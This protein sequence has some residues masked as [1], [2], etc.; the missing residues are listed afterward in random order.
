M[1]PQLP[2]I[3]ICSSLSQK[4]QIR[5]KQEY[6]GYLLIVKSNNTVRHD[7]FLRLRQTGDVGFDLLNRTPAVSILFARLESE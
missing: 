7:T 1:S 4:V 2:A 3:N 6:V 5:Q